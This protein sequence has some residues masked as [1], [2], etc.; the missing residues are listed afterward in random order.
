MVSQQSMLIVDGSSDTSEVL[1]TTF[2]RRGVRVL[3]AERANQ[4]LEMARRFQPD[5][6]VLDVECESCAPEEVYEPFAD[7]SRRRH[8]PLVILGTI[9]RAWGEAGHE[10]CLAK[11]YHYGPLVRT[12]ERLLDE[13]QPSSAADA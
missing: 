6:I 9:Q 8:K 3:S 5:L 4:G 11:P 7:Q 2:E 10:E 12:I 13:A 1:A